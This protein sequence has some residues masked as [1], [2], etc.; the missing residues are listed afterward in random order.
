MASLHELS[1]EIRSERPTDGLRVNQYSI[2]LQG[3]DLSCGYISLAMQNPAI[4]S[5][6]DLS[7]ALNYDGAHYPGGIYVIYDSGE[8]VLGI[9]Y[10]QNLD[11][12]GSDVQHTRTDRVDN[13]THL[14][15]VC[16][17]EGTICV[18]DDLH[19]ITEYSYSARDPFDPTLL[20]HR[21]RSKSI[22]LVLTT[23]YGRPMMAASDSYIAY[24]HRSRI[25]S[26]RT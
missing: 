13:Y 20:P 5:V 8:A 16:E 19:R 23:V 9:V 24:A 25:V 2:D 14:I 18:L 11:S 10:G 7:R 4:S 12:T 17:A 15:P 6:K 26:P 3:E 22:E 21:R 1:R